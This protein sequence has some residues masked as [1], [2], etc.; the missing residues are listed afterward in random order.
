[1]RAYDETM[2]R[3]RLDQY[4]DL[5]KYEIRTKDQS[6]G[7]AATTDTLHPDRLIHVAF[8]SLGSNSQYL[9]SPI[10][11]RVLNNVYD[12]LKVLGAASE[13]TW[14][15]CI[16]LGIMSTEMEAAPTGKEGMASSL[17]EIMDGVKRTG[18]FS[19]SKIDFHQ[20]KEVT[21]AILDYIIEQV[22]IS[23]Q[24][25]KRIFTGSER[26]ELA[27]S[28]DQTTWTD[29]LNRKRRAC[30]LKILRPLVNELMATGTL[31]E[32]ADYEIVWDRQKSETEMIE[33]ELKIAE[34]IEK[35]GRVISILEDEG[36]RTLI[37]D[38]MRLVLEQSA[39]RE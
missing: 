32:I 9:G 33:T 23:L 6:T 24:I 15:S 13:S 34:V 5:E 10:L 38:R 27:S 31:P 2:V 35:H 30:E 22:C 37:L 28:Q 8:D 14:R 3:V 29:T 21:G 26:G 4:G 19:K 17:A 7:A 25:P 1:M 39:P 11:E 16:A 36:L 20:P 18:V 12:A